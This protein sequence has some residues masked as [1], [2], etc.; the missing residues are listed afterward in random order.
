[1]IRQERADTSQYLNALQVLQGGQDSDVL[2]GII[3]LLHGKQ[4]QTDEYE[5]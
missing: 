5:L 4:E 3:G 1:M 2:K